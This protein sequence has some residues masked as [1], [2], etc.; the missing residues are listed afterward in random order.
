M[1]LIEI[2]NGNFHTIAFFFSCIAMGLCLRLLFT[3]YLQ[4]AKMTHLRDLQFFNEIFKLT[5]L[6]DNVESVLLT[7]LEKR[8]EA[9]YRCNE[10]IACIDHLHELSI[11]YHHHI[12][13]TLQGLNPFLRPAKFKLFLNHPG[14]IEKFLRTDALE[15]L[16]Q[17]RD[18]YQKES[19]A[20]KAQ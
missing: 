17:L 12:Y 19:C 11:R 15:L 20:A 13:L 5:T 9:R 16:A 7:E 18:Q 10:R 1:N 14:T 8:D 4:R 2:N 6:T 3:K